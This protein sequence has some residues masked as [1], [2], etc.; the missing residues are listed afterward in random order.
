MDTSTYGN[1][2]VTSHTYNDDNTLALIAH[3]GT[4]TSIGDY[5][6]TWDANKNKLSE[7]ITGVMSGYGFDNTAYDTEDRLATWNRD[8]SNLDQSWNLSPVGDW[9]YIT[10]NGNVQSRTH[11]PTHELLTADSQSVSSDAKGNMTLIPASLRPNALS[12]TWDQDNRMSSASTDGA[13]VSQRFDALGRRVARNNDIYVQ[14]GQ[15]TVAD[16]A[17]GATATNPAYTYVYGSYIDEPV[18]RAGIG[19]LRYYHRG[20]QYSINALTDSSGIVTERYAYTAY[21]TPTITDGSGATLTTSADNNR[22]TY[23]GREWD[24]DLELYHYRARMCDSISGRF[25]SRDPIG[26]SG[27]R[28]SQYAFIGSMPL[29]GI[30]PFGLE[31]TF[32]IKFASLDEIKNV[33][34]EPSAGGYTAV[35]TPQRKGGIEA[36]RHDPK[37]GKGSWCVCGH[38]TVEYDVHVEVYLPTPAIVGSHATWRGLAD[39][40]VHEFKRLDAYYRAYNE[41]LADLPLGE[42]SCCG[43]FCTEEERNAYEVKLLVWMANYNQAAHD[44]FV[45]EARSAQLIIG[46]ENAITNHRY[47]DGPR[48]PVSVFDGHRVKEKIKD[49]EELK[50]KPCPQPN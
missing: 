48:G 25:L 27:S 31:F 14:I 17:S 36:E 11:G 23:T 6:Y 35:P 12:L 9:N 29:S 28:Y 19:T 42:S 2:V 44:K 50:Q 8:D 3:S 20:Q 24:E 21:G 43:C 7:T 45:A 1:G 30:D 16:Y 33:S 4:G 47:I 32:T 40:W 49:F 15:Q 18:M 10:E 39:I 38:S 13:T 5:S 37:D 46:R 22:Y 41:Y 34:G 26:F